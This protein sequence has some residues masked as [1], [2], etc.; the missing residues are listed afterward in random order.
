MTS[1]TYPKLSNLIAIQFPP[2]CWKRCCR[3]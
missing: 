1:F 2:L 3:S